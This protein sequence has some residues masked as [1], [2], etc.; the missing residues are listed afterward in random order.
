[1]LTT[2]RAYRSPGSFAA[3]TR[4]EEL[5]GTVEAPETRVLSNLECR[6]SSR[7]HSTRDELRPGATSSNSAR[8][9]ARQRE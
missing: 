3:S 8:C 6:E 9:S 2:A 4:E 7:I 1:M 5:L